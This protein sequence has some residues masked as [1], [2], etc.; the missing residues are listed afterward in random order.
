MI[1]PRRLV[2]SLLALA[3]ALGSCPAFAQED[4]LAKA[5]TYFDAGAAAYSAGRFQVAIQAFNEAYTLAPRPTVLFSLAQAER[6][7]YTTDHDVRYLRASIKHFRQY[8]ADV[9]QGGRRADAV[10]ALAELEAVASRLTPE[11]PGTA[12]KE[13]K[14]V[15]TRVM[16]A[17]SVK[18]AV[19]TLDGKS[20]AEA[21]VIE[22]VKPG[23][24]SLVVTAKGYVDDRR[25]ITAVEGNL[26]AIEVALR[27]RPSR[28]VIA[29]PDGADVSVDGRPYGN[30]PIAPIDV[31]RGDHVVV[32]THLGHKPYLGTVTVDRGEEKQLRVPLKITEQRYVSYGV[33]AGAGVAA[34]SGT[35]LALMAA[36]KQ[37]V[38]KGILADADAGNLAP[39][40]LD[41]YSSAVDARDH[42]RT[43]SYVTFGVAGALAL[44]GGAL[45]LFDHPTPRRGED[46]APAAPPAGEPPR[47]SLT[48]AIGPGQAGASLTGRF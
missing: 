23:K 44:T 20:Y 30:A 46:S 45:F 27:E 3:L 25:E 21:P 38:A 1:K 35:V 12:E 15:T 29:T 43:A 7:Q 19:I 28:L 48:P 24:H 11:T 32:I 26:V 31:A 36:H 40:R 39:N 41:D 34:V 42:L 6:R 37:S 22:E 4:A 8:V 14:E 2:P 47:V 33:M 5:K 16:I 13:V 17:A 10:E 18:D 9:A